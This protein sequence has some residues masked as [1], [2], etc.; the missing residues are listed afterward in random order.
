MKVAIHVKNLQEN[1]RAR[2][3][4]SLDGEN[5]TADKWE[6]GPS[7]VFNSIDPYFGFFKLETKTIKEKK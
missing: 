6:K 7:L 1:E 4:V 2:I 3:L 5:W